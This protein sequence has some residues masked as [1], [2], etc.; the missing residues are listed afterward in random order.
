MISDAIKIVALAYTALSVWHRSTGLSLA[1]RETA[2]R[3]D[4]LALKGAWRLVMEGSKVRALVLSLAGDF[5]DFGG[6]DETQLAKSVYASALLRAIF[7]AWK[8]RKLTV[9]LMNGK[10]QNF[11]LLQDQRSEAK[12]LKAW[13]TLER[14]H[15]LQ[16]VKGSRLQRNA[17]RIWFERCR[18]VFVTL[19]GS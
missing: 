13:V 9:D 7:A 11:L 1:E 5:T 16:R 10:L 2:I 8:G 17:L 19:E 18:Y 12:V 4:A 15:L 6:S 3:A 14:G